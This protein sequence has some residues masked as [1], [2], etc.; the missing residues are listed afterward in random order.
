MQHAPTNGTCNHRGTN[1]R[2]THDQS[3]SN[4]NCGGVLGTARLVAGSESMVNGPG[5]EA[6]LILSSFPPG[7]S[8]TS[9]PPEMGRVSLIPIDSNASGTVTRTMLGQATS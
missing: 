8:S 5:K 9:A 6:T 7:A 3:S 2:T 1:Q 4:R